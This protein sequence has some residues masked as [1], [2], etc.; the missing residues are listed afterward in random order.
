MTVLPTAT[1]TMIVFNVVQVFLPV[2]L[3][4]ICL[5]CSLQWSVLVSGVPLPLAHDSGMWGC[6]GVIVVSDNVWLSVEVISCIATA[7]IA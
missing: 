4:T 1:A 6:E 7:V 2:P 5:L 3:S